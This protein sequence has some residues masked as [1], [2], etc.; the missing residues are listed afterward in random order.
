[1]HTFNVAAALCAALSLAH[2]LPAR[3][4]DVP[5]TFVENCVHDDTIELHAGA[6]SALLDETDRAGVHAAMM[7]RYTQLAGDAFAPS[8]IL[9]WRSPAYGWLYVAL[10]AHPSKPGK[11]C[12]LATF[13]AP[14]FEFTGDLLRKYFVG[15]RT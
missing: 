1:M 3:A 7:A 12:A 9:L 11:V 10:K 6:D 14:V 5:A 2:P 4:S 8:A 15:A 13:S